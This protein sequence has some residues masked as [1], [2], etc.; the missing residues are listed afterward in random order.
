VVRG[1][2]R[3]ASLPVL[4]VLAVGGLAGCGRAAYVPPASESP[5]VTAAAPVGGGDRSPIANAFDCPDL[6]VVG[7]LPAAADVA[8]VLRCV[9]TIE[10]FPGDGELAVTSDQRVPAASAGSLLSALALPS[11]RRWMDACGAAGVYPTTVELETTSGRVL[12]DPP[13]GPCG[14]ARPEV[15]EAWR[16]APWV[17]VAT[18]RIERLRSEAAVT[19]GCTSWKDMI[20]IDGKAAEPGAAGPLVNGSDPVSICLFRSTGFDGEPTDGRQLTAEKSQRLATLLA[21][22]GPAAPCGAAHTSFAV[23]GRTTPVFVEL[24]GCM[25][26]LAPDRTLRQGGAELTALRLAH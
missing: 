14:L 16:A 2:R 12:I 10:R 18:T 9:R 17:T 26:V 23:I 19:A 4:A 6:P 5:R 21:S 20:A 13:K 8:G 24:D 1:L 22:A 11:E 3:W 15:L 25:R 7:P